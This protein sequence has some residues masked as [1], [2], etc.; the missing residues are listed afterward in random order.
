MMR[1]LQPRFALMCGVAGLLAGCGR[2]DSPRVLTG[3]FQLV[4]V[5]R[6]NLDNGRFDAY[7][8]A[9]VKVSEVFRLALE[10]DLAVEHQ[11]ERGVSIGMSVNHVLFVRSEDKVYRYD[12]VGDEYLV[13]DETRYSAEHLATALRASHRQGRL[14]LISNEK[15]SVTLPEARDYLNY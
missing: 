7:A 13:V 12:I 4:L 15:A 3:S 8:P 9:D 14:V 11:G 5:L 6:R 1:R 2:Q 10:K